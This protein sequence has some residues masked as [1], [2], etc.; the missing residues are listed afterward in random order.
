MTELPAA[1]SGF[2][3]LRDIWV[4]ALGAWLVKEEKHEQ[5]LLF[6]NSIQKQ[7]ITKHIGTFKTMKN[8]VLC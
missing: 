4:K 5:S 2:Y 3:L 6:I 1:N 8:N 7:S